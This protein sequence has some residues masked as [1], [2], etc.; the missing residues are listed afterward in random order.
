MTTDLK[1]YPNMK[2]SGVEWLGEVPEHWAVLPN[3]A[4]FDEVKV[5]DCPDE[6]M[7]SVTIRGGVLRQVELLADSSQKDSSNVDRSSYKL[8]Q[9]G[10]IVYN[11]MRAWQGAI[12]ASDHRGIVSPAYIIQRSRAGG[13][14]RYF[15]RL[16]RTPAFAGEAERW[17]Y[18]I[19]SDMWSLRPEHFRLIHACLPPLVE[20]DAIVRFID[21]VDR[22]IRRYI[23]AKRKLIRLLEEQKQAI[24]NQAVTGQIDVRTGKPYSTYKPSGIEW[25][26]DVPEHWKLCR[27]KTIF[28]QSAIPVRREDEMVTCFR[29]GQVTL[30]RNRRLGGYTEAIMELGYQGI[31]QGQLVLHSMDAFAGAVG[32]SDSNGKCSPE[33]VVCDPKMNGVNILFYG[34]L[35]R[36]LALWGLFVMLC[37]SV[38]ERAPRIRFSTFGRIALPKPPEEEQAVIAEHLAAVRREIGLAMTRTKREIELL[39]EYRT[40]LIADVVTGKLDVREA[41]TSLPDACDDDAELDLNE[42]MENSIAVE[43]VGEEAPELDEEEE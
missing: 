37:S 25:L 34:L 10:D 15:H 21:H 42:D 17:S 23:R 36:S 28:R 14:P 20:Q 40:R 26:G 35:L 8:V 7:L 27:A 5:R 2:D 30:R 32:V 22:R 41:A 31:R 6:E 11:K 1:P 38:R 29:D 43:G 18:G 12:G 19:T 3:R 13:Q 39:N 4:L 16:F 9:A 33:Y 24:I